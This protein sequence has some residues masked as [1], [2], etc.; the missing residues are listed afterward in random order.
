MTTG[1][2]LTG[3]EGGRLAAAFALGCTSTWIFIR[4]LVMKPA[5]KSCHQQ[6]AELRLTLEWVKEQMAMK[7][8]RIGQL[9]TILLTKG[10]GDMRNAMQAALSE[11]HADIASVK[12]RGE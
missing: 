11:I 6:I 4:N 3:A 9:E 8:T 5:I 1:I 7:D 2:D 10:S 12:E